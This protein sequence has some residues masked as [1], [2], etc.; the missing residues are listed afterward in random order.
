M[1]RQI[2][3]PEGFS[4]RF[5]TADKHKN[6]GGEEIMISKAW[7]HK[8]HSTKNGNGNGGGT[9][10]G[11]FYRNPQ[12][13]KNSTRNIRLLSGEIRKIHIR[14]IREFNGKTVL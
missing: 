4:L 6:T 8:S 13:Y 10:D 14:L 9:S 7:K 3:M 2:D 5:I 12:H 11:K 1:L